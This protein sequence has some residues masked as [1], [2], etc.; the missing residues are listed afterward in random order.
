[1]K[2]RNPRA[3]G[4]LPIAGLGLM[5]GMVLLSGCRPSQEGSVV[6]KTP[7]DVSTIGAA[8]KPRKTPPVAPT[9]KGGPAKKGFVPG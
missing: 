2:T 8:P 3:A 5:T 1:M 7:L 4:V 9:R 6:L